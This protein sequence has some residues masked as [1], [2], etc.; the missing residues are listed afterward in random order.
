MARPPLAL[1]RHGTIT[2]KREDGRWVSRCRVRDVDGATRAAAQA[3][4]QDDL[5]KRHGDRP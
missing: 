3:A 1:G 4:L 2:T 5:R